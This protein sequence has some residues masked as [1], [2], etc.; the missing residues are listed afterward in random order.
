MDSIPG[1]LSASGELGHYLCVLRCVLRSGR[2][3]S[4][5]YP[6]KGV[7]AELA[8][9]FL[10]LLSWKR[11]SKSAIGGSASGMTRPLQD[12]KAVLFPV[13]YRA[14]RPRPY[15]LF[16]SL[17]SLSRAI[18]MPISL[19]IGKKFVRVWLSNTKDKKFFGVS[20]YYGGKSVDFWQRYFGE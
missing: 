5:C 3:C 2:A 4:A 17:P 11:P 19:W 12:Y 18:A 13:L 9:Q 8:L 15:N 7:V 20:C 1:G 14:G 16:P 6:G 10:C